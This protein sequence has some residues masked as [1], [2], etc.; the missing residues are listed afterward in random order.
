M[1]ATSLFSVNRATIF[2][3]LFFTRSF[4]WSLWLVLAAGVVLIVLGALLDLRLLFLGLMMWFTVLPTIAFFQFV[5]YMFATDMV[6][7]LLQHSV[8]RRHD[9]Y[10]LHIFR[11]AEPSVA[12][13]QGKK[14]IESGRLT[15]FDSNV[16]K[17]KNTNGYKVLFLKDSP[18]SLLYIPSDFAMADESVDSGLHYC[19]IPDRL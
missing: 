2:K 16:V 18:L 8:E 1:E 7:N 17:I 14:W 19:H 3:T 9:G 13:E 10:L 6:G 11:P 15:I 4:G 5:N 12:V